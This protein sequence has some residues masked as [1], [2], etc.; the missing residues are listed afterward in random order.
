MNQLSGL[1][2]KGADEARVCMAQR[3]DGDARQGIEVTFAGVVEQ[4]RALPVGE[5]D[6]EARIGV[7]QVLH[8]DVLPEI[9]AENDDG[10]SR[11]RLLTLS[12]YAS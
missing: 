4:P 1:G 11:R 10:G 3:I 2:G 8:R 9:N 7:H 6:G 5:G 12:R